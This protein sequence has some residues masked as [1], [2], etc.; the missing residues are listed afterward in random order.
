MSFYKNMPQIK[1]SIAEL[2]PTH[3]LSLHFTHQWGQAS[4]APLTDPASSIPTA[5]RDAGHPTDRVLPLSLP[6]QDSPAPYSL[7]QMGSGMSIDLFSP[8]RVDDVIQG[9]LSA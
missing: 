7:R 2:V 5:A 4:H 6:P 8:A 3:S 9:R 1:R